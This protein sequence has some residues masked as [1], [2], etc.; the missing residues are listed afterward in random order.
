M[1]LKANDRRKNLTF[2]RDEFRG[3]LSDVTVDQQQQQQKCG[4]RSSRFVP[5]FNLVG[6]VKHGGVRVYGCKSDPGLG[7]LNHLKGRHFGTLENIQTAVSDQLKA[8]PISE[9]H[10]CNEEWTKSLQRCE[11]SEGSYFEGDNVEL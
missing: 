2:S 4:H 7:N 6:T 3:S 11:A 1:V 8:I 9:F 10:Q 5:R